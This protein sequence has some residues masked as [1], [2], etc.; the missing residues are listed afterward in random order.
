MKTYDVPSR[1]YFDHKYRDLP[2]GRII[3]ELARTV[4]VELNQEEYDELLDDA[5]HYAETFSGFDVEP[6]LRGLAASARATVRSLAT[7]RY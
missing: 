4:R 2:S 3:K 1:F 6:Y 7:P 5:K